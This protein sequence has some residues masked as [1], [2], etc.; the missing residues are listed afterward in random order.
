MPILSV[1]AVEGCF[2]DSCREILTLYPE[3]LPVQGQVEISLFESGGGVW[4][5]HPA[6]EQGESDDPATLFT[7]AKALFVEKRYYILDRAANL[8]ARSYWA[9]E[10][11]G[12]GFKE[13]A[14][15]AK[16]QR[17]RLWK[18]TITFGRQTNQQ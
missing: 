11:Y 10:F 13:F 3:P 1:P 14:L 18:A 8:R 12:E 6:W 7:Q 4:L 9:H 17:E 5:V 15:W 2:E 16:T